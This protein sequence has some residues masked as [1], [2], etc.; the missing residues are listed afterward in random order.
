MLLLFEQPQ[1]GIPVCERETQALDVRVTGP[2]QRL[3][4]RYL[5]AAS[6][7]SCSDRHPFGSNLFE[8]ATIAFQPGLLAV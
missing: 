2:E 8:S 5:P 6:I 3:D 7:D 4:F 1:F